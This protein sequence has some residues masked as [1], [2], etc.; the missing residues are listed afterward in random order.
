[1]KTWLL[2]KMNIICD[3]LQ[4]LQY[5]TASF[6]F[7]VHFPQCFLV[8]LQNCNSRHPRPF[9]VWRTK[10]AGRHNLWWRGM[11][12][13]GRLL[14]FIRNRFRSLQ[15][16]QKLK[17]CALQSLP[18]GRRTPYHRLMYHLCGHVN[19]ALYSLLSFWTPPIGL[20]D[21]ILLYCRF[22]CMQ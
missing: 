3:L 14:D 5:E 10:F 8:L 2:I 22:S 1:M 13:D 19:T 17:L 9:P 6:E 16:H 15:S 20:T 12:H 7:G 11:I 4:I 18:N 21:K